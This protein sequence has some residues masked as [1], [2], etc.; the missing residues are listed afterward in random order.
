MERS[1]CSIRSR[2]KTLN[3]DR[4]WR[5]KEFFTEEDDEIIKKYYIIEK[6]EIVKRLPNHSPDSIKN[7]AFR[8]GINT[9]KWSDKEIEILNSLYKDN[10]DECISE[11]QKLNPRRN[12]SSI[13]SKA[14]SLGLIRTDCWTELEDDIIKK[15]YPTQG[16]SGVHE[17]LKN[18][19]ENS[20]MS[21]ASQLGISFL[22]GV[23]WTDD[24]I[25]ILKKFYPIDGMGVIKRL[26]NKT[27]NQI[28]YK[29]QQ[30]KIKSN[31]KNCPRNNQWKQE[32]DEIIK[33]YYPSEGFECYKRLNGRTKSCVQSRA[34]ILG[35]KY[36]PNPWT[37]EED[38]ILYKY[39][40]EEG[41]R[42]SNRLPNRLKS[43]IRKRAAK[44]GIKN[45]SQKLWTKEE[46]DI[47]KKY[48]PQEGKDVA[49]RLDRRSDKEVQVR[50]SFLKVKYLKTI[51]KR[52]LC[53][54]TGIIYESVPSA[55]R[56]TGIKGVKNVVGKDNY[57]AG[58]YH[59]KYVEEEN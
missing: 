18:R 35:V 59:W 36:E 42:I 57:T 6:D 34:S 24:E 13:I 46:D 54:E 51:S 44:L 50:A 27:E 23:F 15:Y 3:I 8:I 14:N 1:L 40:S 2:A 30:L 22:G 17:L 16:K 45:N 32:E 53:I 48:Y 4:G 29:A 9:R 39:Y 31:N 26:Q 21:R 20:I 38:D 19:T 7:R 55:T 43:S 28:S 41:T 47:I 11:I 52:V 5:R 56:L 12:K 25:D 49:N 10:L 58:G 37:K 33:K